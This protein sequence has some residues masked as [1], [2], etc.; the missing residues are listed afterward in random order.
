LLQGEAEF[1]DRQDLGGCR[2]DVHP[3][4][5]DGVDGRAGLGDGVGIRPRLRADDLVLRG[6]VGVLVGPWIG[7]GRRAGDHDGKRRRHG[8]KEFDPFPGTDA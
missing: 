5:L 3:A 4:M 8:E 7:P 6:F 2:G 1:L